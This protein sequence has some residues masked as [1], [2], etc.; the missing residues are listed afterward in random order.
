MSCHLRLP[1]SRL[2]E[3]AYYISKVGLSQSTMH[4]DSTLLTFL[5]SA[6]VK[7]CL[8]MTDSVIMARQVVT[9]L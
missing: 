7:E 4:A 5:E 2:K 3:E 8:Y 9:D 1:E 6:P